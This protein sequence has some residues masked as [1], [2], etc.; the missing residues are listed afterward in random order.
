MYYFQIVFAYFVGENHYPY[1]ISKF[2]CSYN[3]YKVPV[4]AQNPIQA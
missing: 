2:E 1:F 3:S 4:P